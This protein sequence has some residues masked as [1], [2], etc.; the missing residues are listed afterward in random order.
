MSKAPENHILVGVRTFNAGMKSFKISMPRKNA[1]HTPIYPSAMLSF[2]SGF[3]TVEW[4]GIIVNMRADGSLEGK[5]EFN[6]SA[7]F[8]LVLAPPVGEE[9]V[10]K[11]EN[12]R[13]YFGTTAIPCRMTQFSEAFLS[14]VNSPSVI[15]IFAMWRTLPA[16]TIHTNDIA[17]QYN[18][19]FKTMFVDT[20]RIAKN[21]K[22]Y[23]ITQEDLIELINSKVSQ[24]ISK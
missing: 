21:L 3:L 14:K 4:N 6:H 11:F 7:I 20:E 23:E 1:K 2:A 17:D 9:L 16:H 24:R 12:D 18:S 15:D 19:A 8:A 13:L 22:K 10:I 5:V